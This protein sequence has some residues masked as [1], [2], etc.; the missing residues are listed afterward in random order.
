MPSFDRSTHHHYYNAPVFQG[1]AARGAQIAW[2]NQTVNQTQNTAKRVTPGYEDV[3]QVVADTLA[4]LSNLQLPEEDFEDA[5]VTGDEILTEVVSEEPD[6]GKIRRGLAALKGLLLP[7][8]TQAVAGAGEGAHELAK[9][10]I[11][12]LGSVQF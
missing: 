3:A 1:S 5:A 4:Q 7:V 8:A 9:T 11:E 6:R 2:N 12:H 10:A